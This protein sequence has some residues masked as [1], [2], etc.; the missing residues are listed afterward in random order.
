MTYIIRPAT[1]AD[2]GFI[3]AL[4]YQAVENKLYRVITHDMLL[5]ALR[6]DCRA[7]VAEDE[8]RVIG[9]SLG[10][11]RRKMLW[12]LFVTPAY[13]NQGIGKALLNIAVQW[14]QQ[15]A[16]YC[17]LFPCKKIWLETEI[18]SRAETFYQSLGWKRIKQ[19]SAREVHYCYYFEA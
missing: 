12:G 17:F 9:F 11:K 6:K 7:W 1:P 10:N 2:V 18:N 14:L 3:L 15:E 13:Q 8:D 5:D 16:R 4:R 19:V